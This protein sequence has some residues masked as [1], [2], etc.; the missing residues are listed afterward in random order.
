MSR[1]Y[2]QWGPSH[3][4]RPVG[5]EGH[6]RRVRRLPCLRSRP[7]SPCSAPSRSRDPHR[8]RPRRGEE[9]E[10]ENRRPDGWFPS[11]VATFARSPPASADPGGGNYG[12]IVNFG[13][14]DRMA[15]HF[16]YL[17]RAAGF[18]GPAGTLFKT[19][20]I[21]YHH[22]AY[23]R[24][25]FLAVAEPRRVH[26]AGART[27]STTR[28]PG[29]DDVTLDR[30]VVGDRVCSGGDLHI[31]G[32]RGALQHAVAADRDE[33]VAGNRDGPALTHA[34]GDQPFAAH[35]ALTSS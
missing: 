13:A 1:Q 23:L 16:G 6:R 30:D 18:E 27:A 28:S 20:E 2:R 11:V 12:M 29:R 34:V 26:R 24:G 3:L 32:H 5:R 7:S 22:D 21:Q 19:G 14:P 8:A 17:A 10:E 9:H 31:T 4:R 35:A 33:Q 15:D 25:R